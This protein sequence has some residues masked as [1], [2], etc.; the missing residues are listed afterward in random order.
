MCLSDPLPYNYLSA[1]DGAFVRD[2]VAVFGD[3]GGDALEPAEI[4]GVD[5]EQGGLDMGAGDDDDETEA[6]GGSSSGIFHQYEEDVITFFNNFSDIINTFISIIVIGCTRR[7]AADLCPT[8]GFK[9]RHQ[10]CAIRQKGTLFTD[11][12]TH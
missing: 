9:N 7:F 3:Y 11:F 1:N 5:F 2:N 12:Y 10:L 4:G 6:F 8:Q